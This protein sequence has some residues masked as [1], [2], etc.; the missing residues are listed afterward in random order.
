M[1]GDDNMSW[2]PDDLTQYNRAESPHFSV[3]QNGKV[4]IGTKIGDDYKISLQPQGMY[5]L[6]D[7]WLNSAHGLSTEEK[8][9]LIEKLSK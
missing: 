1:K 5:K 7:K 2:N 3:H 4:D 9:N 8:T 6:I